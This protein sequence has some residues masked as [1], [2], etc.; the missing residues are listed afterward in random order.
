MVFGTL[1]EG[2]TIAYAFDQIKVVD[3]EETQRK[4]DSAAVGD[5]IEIKLESVGDIRVK[6]WDAE[7]NCPL[8]KPKPRQL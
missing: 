5:K 6:L 8:D 7:T 4:F 2:Y 1:I 3:G